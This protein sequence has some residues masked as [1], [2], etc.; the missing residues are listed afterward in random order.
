MEDRLS[1]LREVQDDIV[2]LQQVANETILELG[3]LPRC[4]Y[5]NLNSLSKLFVKLT[6][7]IQQRLK[8]QSDI[9]EIDKAPSQLIRLQKQGE[10]IQALD[11]GF[12]NSSS[13]YGNS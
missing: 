9:I 1:S 6:L 13:D 10:I 3:R 4:D 2:A 11:L 5:E 8:T 7:S 12:S